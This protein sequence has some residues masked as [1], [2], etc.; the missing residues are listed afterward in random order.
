MIKRFTLTVLYKLLLAGS[1]GISPVEEAPAVPA[2]YW[3]KV[4]DVAT[5]RWPATVLQMS[6]LPLPIGW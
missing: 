3:E 1:E 6:S 4:Q 5:R 2:E